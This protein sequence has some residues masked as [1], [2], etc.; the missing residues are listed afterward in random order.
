ME[1]NIKN[2]YIR[3][4]FN[5]NHLEKNKTIKK[6]YFLIPFKLY[7]ENQKLAIRLWKLYAWIPWK[8]DYE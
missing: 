4:L 7:M 6:P 8:K 2:K 3:L 1:F 5:A